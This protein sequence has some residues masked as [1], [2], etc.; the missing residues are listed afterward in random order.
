MTCQEIK[1]ARQAFPR[2]LSQPREGFRASV[3]A[4]LL[5]AFIPDITPLSFVELGTGSGMASLALGL[6]LRQASGVGVDILPECVDAANRNALLLGLE[7]RL[8]ATHADIHDMA[9]LHSLVR[10]PVDVVLCNPPYHEASAGRAPADAARRCAL[11]DTGD[12]LDAFLRAA[13]A[14]LCHHGRLCCIF[15]PSRLSALCA[16]LD[17]HR[18]GLRRLRGVHTRPGRPAAFILVEARK[19]SAS[20]CTLE[21]PLTLYAKTHRN[22]FSQEALAFCP[23][24]ERAST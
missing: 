1:A 4:L 5:A 16:A 15:T 2:G 7:S 14:L 24:L 17:R 8:A 6:R 21:P 13:H 12:T 20:D 9:A 22:A 10:E 23:W 18:L 11:H 19:D 3:D